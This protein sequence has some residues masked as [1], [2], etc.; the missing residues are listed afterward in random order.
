MRYKDLITK[1]IANNTN[2]YKWAA[3]K[4]GLKNF[5]DEIAFDNNGVLFYHRNNAYSVFD[6]TVN[7][8]GL[9]SV[10][11]QLFNPLI[12]LTFGGRME[13]SNMKPAGETEGVYLDTDF[14]GWKLKSNNCLFYNLRSRCFHF[15][16]Q[17]VTLFLISPKKFNKLH[18]CKSLGATFWKVPDKSC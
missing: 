17:L 9:D 15:N 13:G 6:F 10:K 11:A 8:Q 7:Q 2:S 5:K 12:N 16:C 3:P 1:G 18:N 14:K 4:E